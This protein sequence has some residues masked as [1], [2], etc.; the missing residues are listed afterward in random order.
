MCAMLS[1]YDFELV[2]APED[3]QDVMP[4]LILRPTEGARVRYRRRR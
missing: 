4:S 2:G 3:V 1:R